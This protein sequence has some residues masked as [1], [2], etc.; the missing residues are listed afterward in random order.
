M[1]R[2]MLIRNKDSCIILPSEKIPTPDFT[3]NDD[4]VPWFG[5]PLSSVGGVIVYDGGHNTRL[6]LTKVSD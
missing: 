6:L 4:P 1:Y 3:L 5:E 2:L